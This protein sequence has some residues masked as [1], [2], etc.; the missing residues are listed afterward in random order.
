MSNFTADCQFVAETKAMVKG[1][2]EVAAPICTHPLPQIIDRLLGIIDSRLAFEELPDGALFH[3]ALDLK[4]SEIRFAEAVPDPRT[5]LIEKL[6]AN[7]L[8]N[9]S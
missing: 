6:K 5:E 7:L 9:R 1:W 3:L 2:Q 4:V 8:H